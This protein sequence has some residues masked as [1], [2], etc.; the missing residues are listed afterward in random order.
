MHQRRDA[1]VKGMGTEKAAPTKEG[2]TSRITI[3]LSPCEGTRSRSRSVTA[4]M[5]VG[6]S[7]ESSKI[8]GGTMTVRFT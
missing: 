7:G 3:D 4:R 5:A 6:G 8:E 1:R 2:G